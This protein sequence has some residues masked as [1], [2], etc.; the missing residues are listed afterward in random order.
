MGEFFKPWRRKAGLLT[1]VMA[2]MLMAGWVRSPFVTDMIAY[3]KEVNSVD[4]W[5]SADSRLGWFGLRIDPKRCL[6]SN[7]TETFKG[8]A[9]PSWYT[10]LTSQN[11]QTYAFLRSEWRWFG[12]D[13][14]KEEA[15]FAFDWVFYRT[16]PYW[17]VVVPLTVIS[18]WLLLSKPRPSNQKKIPEPIAKEGGTTT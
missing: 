10:T 3:S 15:G 17:S 16:V 1:L 9:I 12:F 11:R 14:G 7:S 8:P 2:L 5:F 6:A 18:A 13:V 4:Y